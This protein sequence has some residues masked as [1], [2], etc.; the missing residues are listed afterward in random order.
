MNDDKNGM[1]NQLLVLWPSTLLIKVL[2]G[3]LN[4]GAA[5]IVCDAACNAK[6]KVLGN[7]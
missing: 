2:K 3:S 7:K 1:K 4:W 6:L 5:G